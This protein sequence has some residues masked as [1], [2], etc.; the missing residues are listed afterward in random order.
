MH[1]TFTLFPE[2]EGSPSQSP[3]TQHTKFFPV[4]PTAVT[5][6]LHSSEPQHILIKES[7][8]P[9]SPLSIQQPVVDTSHPP[10]SPPVSVERPTAASSSQ[11]VAMKMHKPV[12]LQ[13]SVK[14]MFPTTKGGS[15][16]EP[17]DE[18]AFPT[19]YTV[20]SSS[21][22]ATSGVINAVDDIEKR[23]RARRM[24]TKQVNI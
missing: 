23:G 18:T 20:T 1:V 8:P 7:P 11:T 22:H 15:E 2:Q 21:T 13:T 24:S 14:E 17:T 3:T 10:S 9:N 12:I 19:S 16:K 5:V 6:S 4:P